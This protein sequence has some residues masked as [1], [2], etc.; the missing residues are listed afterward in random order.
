MS[1]TIKK[2]NNHLTNDYEYDE[3]LEDITT[4]AQR[5]IMDQGDEA[6]DSNFNDLEDVIYE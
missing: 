4:A 6:E 3:M 5:E 2:K 1:S